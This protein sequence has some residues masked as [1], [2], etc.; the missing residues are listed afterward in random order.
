MVDLT[1]PA[2]L[3]SGLVFSTMKAAAEQLPFG[4]RGL[5]QVNLLAVV[6]PQ[7]RGNSSPL[8]QTAEKHAPQLP[9]I[10]LALAKSCW[11]VEP[12]RDY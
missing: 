3:A 9:R 6:H 1:G 4:L 5:S 7:D 11:T 10:C 2:T 12:A 8:C